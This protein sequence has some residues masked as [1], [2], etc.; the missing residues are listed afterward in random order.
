MYKFVNIIKSKHVMVTR[1]QICM[2]TN[3]ICSLGMEDRKK[4]QA[5][6]R[7]REWQ[8]T[9][10]TFFQ[11]NEHQRSWSRIATKLQTWSWDFGARGVKT[12]CDFWRAGV[13]PQL[14]HRQRCRITSAW[15]CHLHLWN[16]VHDC[17]NLDAELAP[18][19]QTNPTKQ[20]GTLCRP[21][22]FHQVLAPKWK[23]GC[24]HGT[25]RA[26]WH[27]QNALLEAKRRAVVLTCV[28]SDTET[29][30]LAPNCSAPTMWINWT[31]RHVAFN[32]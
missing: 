9:T 8:W 32:K 11:T 24:G 31:K 28:R 27:D 15:H 19:W 30:M 22:C 10:C 23:R 18:H 2:D 4:W 29:I 17:T 1:I 6:W 7:R 25:Q 12:S 20:C 21:E 3:S 26:P 13:L 5:T 14:L 16:I